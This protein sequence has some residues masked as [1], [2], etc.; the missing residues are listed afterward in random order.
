MLT[1]GLFP[2]IKKESVSSVLGWMVQY[3][4]DRGVRVLLTENA[5]QKMGYPDL[6]CSKEMMLKEITM[7]ITLGGDGTLL[8]TAREIAAA[9]I[10]ICGINM[11]QLGFLTEVELP[12]LSPAL[13][14]LI[15]GEYEIEE[16]VMLDAMILRKDTTIHVSTALND[17]VISKSGVSRMIKL[18]LYVDDELTAN[19]AADGL[20]LATA[21]G[22]TG[23]SLSAGGPIINPKLEVF[24]LTPICPHTLHAKSLVVSEKEE[25]KVRM[26]SNQDDAVLT[27]DGQAVYHLLPDDIVL[28]KSAPFRAQFIK[29]N[30][31][32]YYETLRSKLWRGE[33][34]TNF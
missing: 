13:D 20:I 31:R 4:K 9:G 30:G 6:A 33:V 15:C 21:T 26:V 23:Y 32:S 16:R 1:I 10:P 12:D 8:N 18:K 24:V 3:F 22:S 5:A 11:G 29:C 19:Y 7:G 34:D 14:K 25:I 27:I 17:V 28:V 2:N